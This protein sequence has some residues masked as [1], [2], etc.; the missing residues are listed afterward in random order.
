LNEVHCNRLARPSISALLSNGDERGWRD[1]TKPWPTITRRC[2][3][4]LLAVQLNRIRGSGS[5]SGRLMTREDLLFVVSVVWFVTLC[6]AVGWLLI[7][8]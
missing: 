6:G 8:G 5:Q 3:P 2:D 7:V 1:V 4:R